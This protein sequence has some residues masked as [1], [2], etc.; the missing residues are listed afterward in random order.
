MAALKRKEQPLMEL[1]IHPPK[2]YSKLPKWNPTLK[3]R[4]RDPELINAFENPFEIK[5][6]SSNSEMEST[7]KK[8][9]A[10]N[11]PK[12]ALP[13]PHRVQ[14]DEVI[15]M[16]RR[17]ELRKSKTAPSKSRKSS[18]CSK[19]T[20]STDSLSSTNSGTSDPFLD[21]YLEIKRIKA[22]ILKKIKEDDLEGL[23]CLVNIEDSLFDGI[24]FTGC[25]E[26]STDKTKSLQNSSNSVKETS[27]MSNQSSRPISKYSVP[28]SSS[29]YEN[30]YPSSMMKM[31]KISS[32]NEWNTLTNKMNE[33]YI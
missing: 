20:E 28:L 4:L 26:L 32:N 25:E 29:E 8:Y 21:K 3:Y 18:E 9:F 10:V 15:L 11:L 5:S 16:K 6:D 19:T 31:K 7:K 17:D 13:P 12:C 14:E 30:Y 23:K 24:D 33:C 1:D 2:G 22:L 27:F